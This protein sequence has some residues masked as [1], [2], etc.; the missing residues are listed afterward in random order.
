MKHII[1][2]HLV[3]WK[4]MNKTSQKYLSLSIIIPVYNA[5]STIVKAL[6]SLYQQTYPFSKIILMNDHSTD[7]SVD[8]IY[9]YIRKTKRK[10]I[11]IYHN[12]GIRGM[13]AV[14]NMGMQHVKSDYVIF[15]HSDSALDSPDE[16]AKL[17]EP[18]ICNNK[19]VATYSAVVL[20]I[21]IW[22]RYPFWEKCLLARSVGEAR[23]G[24]N[25][26]FDCIKRS[27]F[28]SIGGY[29]D[30]RYGHELGIGGEDGDLNKRLR[31]KGVV[32]QSTARVI[33]LHYLNDDYSIG[34][35]IANRK[36]LSRSYG[37]LI[38]I[39]GF[40]SQSGGWQFFIKPFLV[41]M[42]PLCY[43]VPATVI[44][45]FLFAFY[46]MKRM[47]MTKESL[48]DWNILILPFITI[49]MIYYETFWMIHSYV[50]LPKSNASTS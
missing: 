7:S 29:D 31:N 10:N 28:I 25:G 13:G 26:K 34:N 47:Y 3:S 36:L 33:H 6:E 18:F 9:A 37:R 1:K 43:F 48:M 40:D 16:I 20:P 50:H 45:Y 15:L 2:K 17:V 14:Y 8:K 35:L 42:T 24:L 32:A 11:H 41:L 23:S 12:R 39:R 49:Y 46:Y 4:S 27:T 5:E 38:R 44:L 22:K 30:I 19:V 21:K